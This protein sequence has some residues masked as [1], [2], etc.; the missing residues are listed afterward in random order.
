M[1]TSKVADIYAQDRHK[2]KATGP[3]VLC[4]TT[5]SEMDAVGDNTIAFTN[6]VYV[7]S[8]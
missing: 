6:F 5:V 2:I 8:T 3:D 1:L 7:H 4:G